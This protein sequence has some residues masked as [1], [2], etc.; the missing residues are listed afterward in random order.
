MP[1]IQVQQMVE[2]VKSMWTRLWH[3]LWGGPKGGNL[4]A[5]DAHARQRDGVVLIDVRSPAEW[6]AGHAEDALH[7]PLGNLT[8]NLELLPKDGEIIAMCQSGLRSGI[9]AMILRSRGYERVF[10][11]NGGFM[12]WYGAG[13]PIETDSRSRLR[14]VRGGSVVSR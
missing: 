6:Q 5:R 10:N 4:S 13:L 7:I 2:G 8:R 3:I 1:L 11:L 9:A 14:R 12:A